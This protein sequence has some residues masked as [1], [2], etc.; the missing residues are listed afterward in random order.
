MLP[1][2]DSLGTYLC[3]LTPGVIGCG[4][5]HTTSLPP[6]LYLACM[7]P[8]ISPSFV[9]DRVATQIWGGYSHA[10]PP[11]TRV[12]PPP[13]CVS[14]TPCVRPRGCEGCVCQRGD[15]G[16]GCFSHAPPPP[17]QPTHVCPPSPRVAQ[18]RSPRVTP[19]PPAPLW[20][21]RY[22]EATARAQAVRAEQHFRRYFPHSCGIQVR[23]ALHLA[24]MD[25]S[26]HPEP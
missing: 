4:T 2:L 17:P 19:P 9:C 26:F 22:G 8:C 15:K 25:R 18:H 20:R 14:L 13:P 6:S 16:M 23:L 5:P 21:H 1:Y 10:P 11:H 24:I 7:L 3:T 12:P